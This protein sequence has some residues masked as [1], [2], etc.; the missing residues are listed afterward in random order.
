MSKHELANVLTDRGQR[1]HRRATSTIRDWPTNVVSKH[2]GMCHRGRKRGQRWPGV[3]PLLMVSHQPTG[4][5]SEA[6]AGLAYLEF[7]AKENYIVPAAA[8]AAAAVRHRSCLTTC[9]PFLPVMFAPH[10]PIR[11]HVCNCD[12]TST[13][14]LV[15]IE[16][17]RHFSHARWLSLTRHHLNLA[18]THT[19]RNI[20][21]SGCRAAS[22]QSLIMM[23]LLSYD[24][25]YL[26]MFQCIW[27]KYPLASYCFQ[28]FHKSDMRLV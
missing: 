25:V 9:P 15:S 27:D 11:E 4:R 24:H 19:R 21:K 16:I 1:M 18:L 10:P 7:P 13:F 26:I 6:G 5:A 14:H 28:Q 22:Q 12:L 17:N 3:P 20:I 23:L 8:M 2:R